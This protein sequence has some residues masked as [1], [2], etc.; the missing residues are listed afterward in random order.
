MLSILSKLFKNLSSGTAKDMEEKK[1][2]DC[3]CGS[4]EHTLSLSLWDWGTDS[5]PDLCA[6]VYLHQYHNV[7]KRIWMALK[8]IFGCRVRYGFFDEM[9]FRNEDIPKLVDIALDYHAKYQLYQVHLKQKKVKDLLQRQIEQLKK[10]EDLDNK[11][12]LNDKGD[13]TTND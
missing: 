11:K 1:H 10:Q 7:F 5:P 4:P 13:P 6:H 2:F 3:I 12:D 9:I 8:Y